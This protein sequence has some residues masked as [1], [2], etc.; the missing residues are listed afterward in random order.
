MCFPFTENKYKLHCGGSGGWEW[1]SFQPWENPSQVFN[2]SK[3]LQGR[4]TPHN[5]GGAHVCFTCRV[6]IRH[7][8]H[9]FQHIEQAH[10][11][12]PA[13]PDSAREGAQGGGRPAHQAPSSPAPSS[14]HKG[15]VASV[16]PHW[17]KCKT[18]CG[19]GQPRTPRV[20]KHQRKE[21]LVGDFQSCATTGIAYCFLHTVSEHQSL[22]RALQRVHEQPDKVQAPKLVWLPASFPLSPLFPF[23]FSSLSASFPP[24]LPP[25][26]FLSYNWRG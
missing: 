15:E 20:F 22:P 4:L 18:F 9:T 5:H 13:S 17:K 6:S 7:R 16:G 14:K 24:S 2:P 11:G 23:P 21:Q 10:T 1:G 19:A 26:F 3:S 25:F 12:L 8:T